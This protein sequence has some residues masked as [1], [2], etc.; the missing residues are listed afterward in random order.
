MHLNGAWPCTCMTDS[1]GSCP[2][3][4][5]IKGYD[6]PTGLYCVVGGRVVPLSDPKALDALG[7]SALA[8]EDMLR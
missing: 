6:G 4:R 2:C 7:R 8:V 5:R 3:H 1:C